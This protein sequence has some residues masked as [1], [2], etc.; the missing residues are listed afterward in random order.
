MENGGDAPAEVDAADV[1]AVGTLVWVRRNNGSWWPGRV[2]SP[3][4]VPDCCPAPPRSPATPILLLG[5]RDGPVFVYALSS[6]PLSSPLLYS[7]DPD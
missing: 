5:R 7:G 6:P 2:V 1:S 4:D 3:N